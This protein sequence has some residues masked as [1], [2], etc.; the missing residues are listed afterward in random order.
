[1]DTEES[2]DD[3]GGLTDKEE[4][5]D[6]GR[7]PGAQSKHLDMGKQAR[8]RGL[9]DEGSEEKEANGQRWTQS[10]ALCNPKDSGVQQARKK[11]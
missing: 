3:Q 8:G 6:V 10:E 1:M 2:K 5:S 7:E 9:D 4:P 11:V